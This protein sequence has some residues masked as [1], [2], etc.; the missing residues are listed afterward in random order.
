[1]TAIYNNTS[2]KN[3]LSY[4]DPQYI[5]DNDSQKEKWS[6]VIPDEESS[7]NLPMSQGKTIFVKKN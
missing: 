4:Y 3:Y 6:F 2:K 1:M 5:T 7:K